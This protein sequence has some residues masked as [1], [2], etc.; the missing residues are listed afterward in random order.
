MGR[1]E[2]KHAGIEKG[3]PSALAQLLAPSYCINIQT[4]LCLLEWEMGAKPFITTNWK[5]LLLGCGTCSLAFKY[6]TK[7]VF[8]NLLLLS[9][10]S[11]RWTQTITLCSYKWIEH[12]G[13]KR[14][15]FSHTRNSRAD[16]SLWYKKKTN[17]NDLTS[18]LVSTGTN[19][20]ASPVY[21]YTVVDG[22]G[23]LRWHKLHLKLFRH[24]RHLLVLSLLWSICNLTR[25]EPTL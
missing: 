21:L 3:S 9:C 24:I 22:L 17:P 12:L 23:C 11:P 1:E 8:V 18:S 15:L 16:S 5:M 7:H 13:L 14:F 2:R 4:P 20:S 19:K 25:R 6:K 10:G